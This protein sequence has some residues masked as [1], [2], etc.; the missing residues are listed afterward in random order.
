MF[1]QRLYRLYLS[2]RLRQFLQLLGLF[3][4]PSLDWT[5]LSNLH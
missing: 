2:L 5:D 4:F 1:S 3:Q